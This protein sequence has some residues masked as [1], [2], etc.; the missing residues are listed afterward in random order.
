MTV[1]VVRG[2][3]EVS[4]A[5]GPAPCGIPDPLLA[6]PKM[7]GL[8]LALRQA[9]AERSGSRAAAATKNGRTSR[10]RG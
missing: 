6:S 10:H 5:C 8:P 4:G 2:L 3:I 1:K 9:S 7:I